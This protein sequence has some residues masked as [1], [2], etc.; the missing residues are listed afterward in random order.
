MKRN[1]VWQLLRRNISKLQLAGYAAASVTGLGIV[2][3]ALQFYLDIRSAMNAEDSFVSRD[4]VIISKRVGVGGSLLSG[5]NAD[6]SEAD[7]ADIEAQPWTR[8]V[9]RFTSA[10]YNVSGAIELG[11]RRMS[12]YLFFESIPDEFFDALPDHWDFDPERDTEVPIII[13][14][15]YLTLYNF[16]FASSRGMPQISEAM[17][18]MVPLRI[19][20]S[21]NGRQQWLDGRIAGFSSRLNTIAVPESFMEWANANFA[22]EPA[23]APSRL[24]IEVNTPGDP[25][26][27]EYLRSHDY[28]SAGDK[29]DNGKAAYFL[30]VITA[31]VV[32]VG[33]VISLL[34]F[35][36]L[37]LSIYLLLQKNHRKLR[38]LMMLGYGPEDVARGYY[39]LIGRINA[40]VLASAIVITIFASLLWR[41]P[42]EA[43]GINA[44]GP[45]IPIGAGIVLMALITAGNFAAI[46]RQVRRTFPQPRR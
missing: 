21:G 37:M 34:A 7:I 17:L 33:I 36:I 29:V 41:A 28:E 45:W 27:A 31:V 16:G 10:G 3:C 9:G 26:I 25:A 44:A 2:L 22:D 11:G 40:V 30:S 35:F 32:A 12:T 39:L 42:L 8:R 24:I 46:R 20:I 23:A 13:S 18:G 38:S 15:D 43:L 1:L 5:S 6:F 14:K 19:S 4:Y